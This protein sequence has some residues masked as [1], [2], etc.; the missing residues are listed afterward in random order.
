MNIGR[1]LIVR[2]WEVKKTGLIVTCGW[3]HSVGVCVVKIIILLLFY[4]VSFWLVLSK[5]FRDTH[6][7]L[8][9][10]APVS[11]RD[12]TKCRN[13]KFP[14]HLIV[15]PWFHFYSQWSVPSL[16]RMFS[17]KNC[18]N[19]Q[20]IKPWLGRISLRRLCLVLVRPPLQTF[21]IYFLFIAGKMRNRDTWRESIVFIHVW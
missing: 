20:P 11:I 7:F 2:E 3:I 9:S 6:L 19:S 12:P 21:F 8:I 17:R 16:E 18:K 5:A 10:T 14:P 15:V 4:V 1:R 13:C